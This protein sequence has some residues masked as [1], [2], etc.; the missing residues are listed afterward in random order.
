MLVTGHFD[1]P[2]AAACRVVGAQL[3]PDLQVPNAAEV[4]LVCREAFVVT[5]VRPGSA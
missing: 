2:G 1:D 4:V 3:E 5:S